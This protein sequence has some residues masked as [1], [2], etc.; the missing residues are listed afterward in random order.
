M[1]K[2]IGKKIKF[3]VNKMTISVN[4]SRTIGKVESVF[5]QTANHI[6]S[7]DIIKEDQ[8]LFLSFIVITCVG[9]NTN[10]TNHYYSFDSYQ[11]V[12]DCVKRSAL[13]RGMSLLYSSDSV[14]YFSTQKVGNV[15]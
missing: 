8:G 11:D 3:K 7:L 5:S 9:R 10:I 4:D 6:P 2:F 1:P 15:F 14:L 13:G 12:I